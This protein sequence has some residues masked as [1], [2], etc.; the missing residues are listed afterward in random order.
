MTQDLT[1]PFDG[2]ITIHQHLIRSSE[3]RP[4]DSALRPDAGERPAWVP[5][6]ELV[7]Y[8]AVDTAALGLEAWDDFLD[9]PNANLDTA[10]RRI[11]DVEGPVHFRVLAERLLEAAGVGRLGSRIRDS[12]QARLDALEAGGELVQRDAFS[13]WPEQFRV[14]RLRDWSGVADKLRDLDYVPDTELMLAIF[15][16]VLEEEGIPVEGAMNNG[17]HRMGFIRLTDNAKARLRPPLEAL[18]GEGMVRIEDGALWLGW[19]AF[20]RT[21]LAAVNTN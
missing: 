1:T 17:I 13:G 18:V 7:A 4:A 20:R 19:E 11:I 6:S 21:P 3:R 15:H 16:A 8:A 10:I 9:I 14:P 12:I 2:V 5:T